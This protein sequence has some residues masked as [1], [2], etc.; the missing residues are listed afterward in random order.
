MQKNNVQTTLLF[1]L[2]L[3]GLALNRSAVAQENA[4]KEKKRIHY[5]HPLSLS[6][7]MIK[8]GNTPQIPCISFSL[9]F[10]KPKGGP[11]LSYYTQSGFAPTGVFY[12]ISPSRL[13][14][15][16]QKTDLT[17]AQRNA[18]A[19]IMGSFEASGVSAAWK[20]QQRVQMGV[21]LGTYQVSTAY[22][23]SSLKGLGGKAFV[24]LGN[25]N[26]GFVELTIIAPTTRRFL[27]TQVSFGVHF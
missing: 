16:P 1:S 17:E 3:I 23:Y 18:Y 20:T 13:S 8:Q 7:G 2:L 15:P 14:P 27:S 12:N 10:Y 24:R 25:L 21:G 6:F 19:K 5:I 9:D 26:A 11:T 22:G 4:P